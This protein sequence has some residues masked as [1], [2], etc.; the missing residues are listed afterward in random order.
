M[1]RW[2]TARDSDSPF[3]AE[4]L[5]ELEALVAAELTAAVERTKVLMQGKA[6]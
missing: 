1:T 3:P 5:A 4:E 6:S 2:R